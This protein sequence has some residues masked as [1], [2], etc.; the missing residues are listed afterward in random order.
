MVSSKEDGAA[1]QKL[2]SVSLGESVERNVEPENNEDAET[3]GTPAKKCSACGEKSD[4]L[5]KCTACKCVWYCDKDCQNRH[6]KVHRKECKRIKKELVKR[7]GKLDLGDEKDLGPLPDLLPREE[8]PI[9][10]RALPFQEGLQTYAVCCGKI[11]CAGCDFQHNIQTKKVNVERAKM[12][13]PQVG[14]TCAFCR[15][16]VSN[17]DEEMLARIRKRVEHKDPEAVHCM[18]MHYGYGKYG[19]PVDQA[20]CIDL[21]R[22][23]AGLGLADAQH[24]LGNFHH[25]GGMGLGQNEEEALQYWDKAAKGGNVIARHNL[26]CTEM[27]N[28]DDVAAMCNWRLCASGGYRTSMEV[29]VQCFEFGFL[30]HADLAEV[31]QAMYLAIADLKSEDRDLYIEHLKKTGQ[32]DEDYEL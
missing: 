29:L 31:L 25:N 15:V 21:L 13:Q 4:T 7:G 8:C 28:G 26:G 6:W 5:K 22:E 16:P 2:S 17:S 23:S 32:Y 20:K 24:Q 1:A 18:A 11:L 10:M 14:R 9:C 19:L 30:H 3:N 27:E 12:Q